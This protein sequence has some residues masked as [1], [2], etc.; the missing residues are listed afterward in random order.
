MPGVCRS[1]LFPF[2]HRLLQLLET[3][4]SGLINYDYLTVEHRCLHREQFQ[5]LDQ[6]RKFGSPVLAVARPETHL[7][8]TEMADQAVAIKF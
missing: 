6:I 1:R 2:S 8:A 7:A 4:A 5:G 3:T